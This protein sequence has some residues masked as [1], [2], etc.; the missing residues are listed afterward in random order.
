LWRKVSD[1]D[2][3]LDRSA[4]F[5]PELGESFAFQLLSGVGVEFHADLSQRRNRLELQPLP[6]IRIGND[7][8]ESGL[9][10]AQRPL[11]H[12]LT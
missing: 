8:L 7:A 10:H 12:F 11:I 4:A 9:E 6:E 5:R 3:S 1:F 2:R